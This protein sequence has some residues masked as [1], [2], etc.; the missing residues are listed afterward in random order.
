MC[1]SSESLG[2]K[3]SVLGWWDMQVEGE[4]NRSSLGLRISTW[5]YEC[6]TRGVLGMG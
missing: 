5:V 2:T 6:H 1:P 3:T 4:I